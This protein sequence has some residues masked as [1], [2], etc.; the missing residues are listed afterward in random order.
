MINFAKLDKH[1]KL[2]ANEKNIISC[3]LDVGTL[4]ELSEREKASLFECVRQ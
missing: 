2:L 1:N 3:K 4:Y